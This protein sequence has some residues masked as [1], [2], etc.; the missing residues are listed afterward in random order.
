MKIVSFA[1]NTKDGLGESIEE[2]I[3]SYP[4]HYLFTALDWFK[5][6]LIQR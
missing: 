5:I 6:Y 1:F 3:L 2:K 4:L